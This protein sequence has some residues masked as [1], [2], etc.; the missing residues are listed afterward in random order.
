[1]SINEAFERGIKAG[2]E[3]VKEDCLSADSIPQCPY[4]PNSSEE[5]EWK[6][7]FKL[8]VVQAQKGS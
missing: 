6:K 2:Q 4:T 7:G 5:E 1:M 8:G 3:W